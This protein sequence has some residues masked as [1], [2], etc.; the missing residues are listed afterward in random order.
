MSVLSAT[1]ATSGHGGCLAPGPH[2]QCEAASVHYARSTCSRWLTVC[3]QG[4]PV[5]DVQRAPAPSSPVPG[6][7]CPSRQARR[8]RH[9]TYAAPCARAAGT[10]SLCTPTPA[11][12]GGL[13]KAVHGA[14][15]ALAFQRRNSRSPRRLRPCRY[16]PEAGAG[17]LVHP[18]CHGKTQEWAA[19]ERGASA[20]RHLLACCFCAQSRYPPRP[21][22]PHLPPH[23]RPGLPDWRSLQQ[24]AS[25]TGP[26]PFPH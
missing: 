12:S 15:K 1:T 23:P 24:Y 10:R 8:H 6:G 9:P 20:V 18:T 3:E 19:Q 14:A 22:R 25:A 17:C 2:R 7:H 11:H 21:P 16:L 4:E 26:F 5:S 13:G